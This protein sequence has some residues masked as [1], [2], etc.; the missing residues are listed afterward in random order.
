MRVVGIVSISIH[1]LL[2]RAS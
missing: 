2:C 1:S